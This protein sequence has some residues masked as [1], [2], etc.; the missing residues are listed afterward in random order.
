M[1]S[2]A[3]PVC[4]EIAARC[5]N[6]TAIEPWQSCNKAF[7]IGVNFRSTIS[8]ILT[9][10]MLQILLGEIVILSF[11]PGCW[12]SKRELNTAEKHIV[13]TKYLLT[14]HRSRHNK[15]G[16]IHFSQKYDI[17]DINTIS[18]QFIITKSKCTKNVKFLVIF[19]SSLMTNFYIHFDLSILGRC[20]FNGG[21]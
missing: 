8:D 18:R 15:A 5:K 21:P 9:D 6:E 10:M 14:Q 12:L 2:I 17:F 1:T 4:Q 20:A 19:A 7:G 16:L 3:K 13:Y 11:T